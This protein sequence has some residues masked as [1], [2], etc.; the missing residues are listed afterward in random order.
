MYPSISGACS[1]SFFSKLKTQ[2]V[3]L[4]LVSTILT[5]PTS[6]QCAFLRADP[7]SSWNRWAGLRHRTPK[8]NVFE[9]H[10]KRTT[11]KCFKSCPDTSKVACHLQV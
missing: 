4:L 2:P 10:R 5:K 1:A 9:K 8:C 3:P 7:K 6:T 11:H